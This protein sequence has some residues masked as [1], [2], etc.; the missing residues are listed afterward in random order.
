V[1]ISQRAPMIARGIAFCGFFTSS[2]AVATASS[3]M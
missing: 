1:T 2:D 3:P